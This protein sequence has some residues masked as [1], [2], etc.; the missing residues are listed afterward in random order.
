MVE[1]GYNMNRVESGRG[2]EMQEDG[3]LQASLGY[4][5]KSCLNKPHSA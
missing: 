2:G 3:E 1:H 4:R 5:A